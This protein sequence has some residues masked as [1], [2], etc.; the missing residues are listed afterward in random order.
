MSLPYC[1]FCS[2][3]TRPFPYRAL[4]EV[5]VLLLVMVVVP[6]S[7][8]LSLSL[9]PSLERATNRRRTAFAVRNGIKHVTAP[10]QTP[11]WSVEVEHTLVVVHV[12]EALPFE[13]ATGFRFRATKTTTND[14]DDGEKGRKSF[15]WAPNRFPNVPP[16]FPTLTLCVYLGV[17]VCKG[18]MFVGLWRVAAGARWNK[19]M[20][21]GV[22]FSHN[23][24]QWQRGPILSR[25][26]A[27]SSQN[28]NGSAE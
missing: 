23:K 14:D 22:V 6:F 26:M 2:P 10:P 1:P 17:C 3:S 20:A 12:L 9:S 27:E 13:Q 15:L 28:R 7:Y 5:T 16:P 19:Q 11:A 18:G 25:L 4:L 21:S 8:S 24:S